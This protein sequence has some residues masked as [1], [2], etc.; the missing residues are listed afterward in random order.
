M[1]R[2]R[3]LLQLFTENTLLSHDVISI[4]TSYD[5]HRFENLFN[6]V[7]YSHLIKNKQYSI[8]EGLTVKYILPN[9]F[10]ISLENFF[11][12][13]ILACEEKKLYYRNIHFLEH[14]MIVVS[15]IEF[16]R[17]IFNRIEIWDC[18]EYPF[19]KIKN[20]TIEY[21][22]ILSISIND[23]SDKEENK[24]IIFECLGYETFYMNEYVKVRI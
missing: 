19:K 22:K 23:I 5:F 2:H 15:K 4:I 7:N 24:Q 21:S 8:G 14:L 18:L 13:S 16:N 20:T 17:T 1:E 3:N 6:T 12:T 11:T 10:N 9:I